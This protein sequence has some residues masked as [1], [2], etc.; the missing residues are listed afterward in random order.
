LISTK[1]GENG[2]DTTKHKEN[3]S[4]K[5]GKKKERPLQQQQTLPILRRCPVDGGELR[6]GT[7]QGPREHT[8]AAA[9]AA[10]K[11]G[12][13]PETGR[14]VLSPPLLRSPSP[15]RLRLGLRRVTNQEAAR[16]RPFLLFYIISECFVYAQIFFSLTLSANAARR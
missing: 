13:L 6:S 1:T 12:S 14:K 10:V 9:G 16:Q 15:V 7:Q 11:A 3:Y 2:Q 4:R 5:H 8:E